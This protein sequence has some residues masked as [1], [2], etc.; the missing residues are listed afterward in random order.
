[1]LQSS[2][3]LKSLY[4]FFNKLI[5]KFYFERNPVVNDGRKLSY[6]GTEKG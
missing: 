3:I 5:F 4:G 2:V 6:R 1:M